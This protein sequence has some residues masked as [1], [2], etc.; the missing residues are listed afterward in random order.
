MMD[1]ILDAVGRTPLVELKHLSPRREVRLFAKLEG[2]NPTGSVKD[3]IAK[4]MI[5]KA[6]ADGLLTPG[7]TIIEATTGNTGIALAMVGRRKGYRVVTVVPENVFPE[8]R[9]LLDIYG[10]EIVWSPGQ[11]GTKGAIELAERLAKEKGYFLPYQ[12]GNPANPQAHYETTGVEILEDLPDVHAFVAG[13]GTGGTVMGVGR[14]LREANPKVQVIAAEPHPGSLLQGLK[15]LKDG[16]IPPVLD[17]KRL[18]GKFL[19]DSRHAF[20]ATRELT[21][22]EGILAGVSSGAVLHVA[23][24]V[25]RRMERGNVVVLLADGGWKYLSSRLWTHPAVEHDEKLESTIWW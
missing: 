4:Y 14:R 19:V 23:L 6:E 18:D 10:A 22:K 11:A 16:Y 24:R 3:R 2:H 17:L 5:E 12:F 13:L 8:I 25:A 21:V 7:Q 1:G 15:S 20:A 9:Q